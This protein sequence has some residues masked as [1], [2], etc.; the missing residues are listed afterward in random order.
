MWGLCLGTSPALVIALS[1][2]LDGTDV[3]GCSDE[4]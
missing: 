3:R 4:V 2:V 1:D